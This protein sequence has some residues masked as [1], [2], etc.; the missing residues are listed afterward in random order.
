MLQIKGFVFN[1]ASENTYVIYNQNKNAWLIDPGNSDDQE[2]KAIKNFIRE[3]ELNI[4]K[5][6]LTHAHIDHILGLQWASDTFK[7]PVFMHKEDKEVLDMFQI[8]GMRFGM[9]LEHIHADI[10]Y[11]DEN[12]E[13]AIHLAHAANEVGPDVSPEAG[14]RLYLVAGNGQHLRYRIHHDAYVLIAMLRVIRVYSFDDDDAAAASDAGGGIAKA[15]VE[16]HHRDHGPPEVDHAADEAWHHG[17]GSDVAV[18]DD[19][20][21]PENV[22]GKHLTLDQEGQIL[23]IALIVMSQCDWLWDHFG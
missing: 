11:I 13:L 16:V 15:S 9:E 18:F 19:F 20:F 14:G 10:R 7:V 8:S 4:E 12:D 21:D 23:G 6:V 22:D 17:D 5:I 1:F 3:K 2:T